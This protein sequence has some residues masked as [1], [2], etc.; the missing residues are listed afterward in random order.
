M[1][2]VAN[3]HFIGAGGGSLAG[4]VG[5]IASISRV[6]ESPIASAIGDVI[7]YGTA[8]AL[9][10]PEEDPRRQ[11]ARNYKA[12]AVGRE[13]ENQGREDLAGLIGNLDIGALATAPDAQVG[14]I[15]K[16]AYAGAIRAGAKPDDISSMFQSMLGAAGA[17]EGRLR[18]VKPQLA[19]SNQGYTTDWQDHLIDREEGGKNSRNATDN[20][21]RVEDARIRERGAMDREKLQEKGRMDRRFDTPVNTPPSNTVMFSPGDPRAPA[22]KQQYTAPGRP[23]TL[24]QVIAGMVMDG[25]YTGAERASNLKNS[26]KPPLDVGAGDVKGINEAIVS[27]IPES[28]ALPKDLQDKVANRAAELYQQTRNMQSSVSQAWEELTDGTQGE[29]WLFDG[30]YQVKPRDAGAPAPAPQAGPQQYPGAPPIGTVIDGHEYVGGDPN[31]QRNWPP[32]GKAL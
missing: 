21:A 19:N 15:V 25:D 27:L 10:D 16:S 29:D 31:D 8:A 18:G 24:D 6:S 5:N 20:A 9:Y 22:G 12:E 28:A 2:R 1:A 11:M 4:G 14:Q 32:A 17:G 7:G 23:E 26:T 3:P 30:P 13:R